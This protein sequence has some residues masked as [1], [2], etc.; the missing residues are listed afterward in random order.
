MKGNEKINYG[1]DAPKV[2]RNLVIIGAVLLGISMFMPNW[3]SPNVQEAIQSTLFFPGI[4]MMIGG[5]L[6]YMYSWG[7]KFKH[8]ERILNLYTWKGDE[9]VLDVGTGLGL[10]MIGAAKRLTS[11]KAYGI[12]IFNTYDLSDNSL[13]R[14]ILNTQLEGVAE[15]TIIVKENILHTSFPDEKFDIIV[16]NLCLHNIDTSTERDNACREMYRILKP[17]GKIIVS[18]FKNTA[19]YT[20]VFR[21]L[22]MNVKQHGTYYFDTFPPLTIISADKV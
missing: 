7:G 20:K 2:I 10:L 9:Q 8:R 6:M 17:Q 5:F 14:A 1:I 19:R 16:S 4:F 3:G 21:S 22:G 15:K 11:G 18:D 12:D 13:E